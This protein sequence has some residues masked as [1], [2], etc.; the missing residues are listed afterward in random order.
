MNRHMRS[1]VRPCS[2]PR[3]SCRPVTIAPWWASRIPLALPT[4]SASHLP[5]SASS[6]AVVL[7]DER[8]LAVEDARVLVHDPR[9]LGDRGEER[10]VV[11]MVVHHDGRVGALAVQ[12]G[13]EEHG[14]RDVPF[15]FD[16][17]AVGVET[18]D[19]GRLHLVPPDAPRVAPH[20]A[21]GRR[22]RDVSRQ[23]L[24]PAFVGE[25]AERARELL[26]GAQL[27]ADAGTRLRQAHVRTLVRDTRSVTVLVIGASSGLGAEVA[28]DLVAS[29]VAVRAMTRRADAPMPEGVD[30]RARR[31][32]RSRR[33]CSPRARV[34]S[35]CFS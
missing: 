33:R 6:T 15:A 32:R 5:C 31:P 20:P 16:D 12:L 18:K 2:T 30:S 24:V 13:V 28:R 23:V 29:G 26:L 9:E 1:N 34:C 35:G 25:D 22:P 19:V 3:R 8:E 7:V 4:W 11:R 21:V 10:R 27:V 17:R 14:G